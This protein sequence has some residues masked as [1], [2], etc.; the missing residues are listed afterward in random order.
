MKT[1]FNDDPGSQGGDSAAED[2]VI[3]ILIDI[4]SG[5]GSS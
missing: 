5:P 2:A 3:E 4:A 1:R